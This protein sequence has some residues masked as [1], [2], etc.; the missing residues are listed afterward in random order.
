MV[1]NQRTW[2]NRHADTRRPSNHHTDSKL[3]SGANPWPRSCPAPLYCPFSEEK[4]RLTKETNTK[5]SILWWGINLCY[6]CLFGCVWFTLNAE[7]EQM[8]ATHLLKELRWIKLHSFSDNFSE[9]VVRRLM[10]GKL[11]IAFRSCFM[12]VLHIVTRE[13]DRA[14][15]IV[16]SIIMACTILLCDS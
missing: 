8:Q 7:H 12:C 11:A 5:E 4:M 3:S 6:F 15:L 9:S 1:R 16:S 10:Y 2:K 13:L 14:R